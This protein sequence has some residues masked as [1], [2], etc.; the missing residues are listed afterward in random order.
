M[1]L[2]RYYTPNHSKA[3]LICLT[4]LISFHLFG[5]SNENYVISYTAREAI[6]GDLT[7]KSKEQVAETYQ[8]MDGLGR[9]KQTVSR[10]ASPL[11][12]DVI[13]PFQYDQFGRQTVK[14]L[15]Y[16]KSTSTTGGF[17]SN[18][19]AEIASFYSAS[20]DN[21]ADETTYYYS[22]SDLEP[23]PLNRLE[24]A[25]GPGSAWRSPDK[26]VNY[27][28]RNNTSGD[29][30]KLLKSTPSS[31]TY[32]DYP[33]GKLYVTQIL[34]ENGRGKT[35]EFM[36]KQ[37]KVILK[38]VENNNYFLKTYYIYNDF[39][40]LSFVVQPAGIK[41]I[42]DNSD[43]SL[44]NVETFRKKWMFCYKY[45][46]RQRMIAKRVPGSDWTYMVYDE[47]DRLVLTQSGNERRKSVVSEDIELEFYDGQ[48]YL[49][50]G[51]NNS[52]TLKPGFAFAASDSR[53]FIATTNESSFTDDDQWLFTKYDELNRPVLTG[54]V[55][56]DGKDHDALQNEV[57]TTH[58]TV[59][60]DISGANDEG[61]ETTS[62]PG[63][64]SYE[65]LTATYYDNYDFKADGHWGLSGSC[66]TSLTTA[67]PLCTPRNQVTGSK[68]KVIGGGF[69]ESFTF[70]D[71]RY[72]VVKT[73]EE[74]HLGGKETISTEYYNA[75]SPLVSKT[76]RDHSG[77]T[78]KEIIEEYTY[79]HMDRVKT[80]KTTIGSDIST[81]TNTYNEI[82][83][84]ITKDL[85]GAQTVDYE[86][87]IR[88]WL[89]KIN[90]G[91][92]FSGNDRFGMELKYN[93]APNAQYN[94]NIGQM[95]WKTTGGGLNA[96]QQDYKYTYDS[97]NR[98]KSATYS[99]STLNNH[100][101]VSDISYDL[102]G[103]IQTLTRKLSNTS[104]DILD[105]DYLNGNQ[106]SSV[107]DTGTS[108]LFEDGAS[109]EHEYVYDANGNMIRDLN[110]EIIN[111]NY[112]HL[113]LPELVKF[114]DD[115]EVEY[116][117]DASGRKLS[118]MVDDGSPETTHY[119]GGIH[120]TNTTIKFVQVPDG[121]Y[122]FGTDEYEYHL[123]DHLGNV[124]ATVDKD[125][126]VQQRDD[127]YPFGLTF[128]SNTPS[129]PNLYKYNGKEEQEET[130]WLDYG[131]RM[132]DGILGRWHVI[133]PLTENF[134]SISAYTYVANN[135]I[136][137]VDPNGM[138][139]ARYNWKTGT[140]F[141][142]GEQISHGDFLSTL[143]KNDIENDAEKV[144]GMLTKLMKNLG[145][146]KGEVDFKN[147]FIPK[148]AEQNI[149][150]IESESVHRYP[151]HNTIEPQKPSSDMSSY[152]H[153]TD[154]TSVFSGERGD[155]VEGSVTLVFINPTSSRNRDIRTANWRQG[156]SRINKF[157][158]KSNEVYYGYA[159]TYWSS[160][161]T[162]QI[163]GLIFSSFEKR[164]AYI[165]NT[166]DRIRLST[167]TKY[168]N[169]YIGGNATS[170]QRKKY[171]RY[172]NKKYTEINY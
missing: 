63:Q 77:P 101:N 17:Q 5:Q 38:E 64:Q 144:V 80:I 82:G 7:G 95:L 44:L 10:R 61:Y 66:P 67:N 109:E 114:S 29:E 137:F 58:S 41:E 20:G 147:D 129:T 45:D 74:N 69:L 172:V 19:T 57:T 169:D 68:I 149:H 94:G 50:T 145:A 91:T 113:N 28:Y 118:M 138:F 75:V 120:Y 85:S 84:L 23:S 103:N 52:I 116:T 130:G 170:E 156:P 42:E 165:S 35:V 81:I 115:T 14:H 107:D 102:N 26:P 159:I 136:Y 168:Y 133:D 22:E 119:V 164:K 31:V 128:N 100:F 121:R 34:D 139:M 108:A 83:E 122:L 60:Y 110:K 111:I 167:Y 112:N 154:V 155:N 55:E 6:S 72:R 27:S 56:I 146:A 37:G 106:L 47:R 117:Y 104:V 46:D 99:S 150:D 89:R 98:I 131:A 135:P 59:K 33:T 4:I 88:G 163:A 90:G 48:S 125:G 160:S 151:T 141:K 87:N 1:K 9:S 36:D 161:G 39:G 143:S 49:V 43:W 166:Y 32:T 24:N 62:F 123:T 15:P 16:V 97:I 79:D 73:I 25:L 148:E 92:S 153:G 3:F 8:Y 132:Y 152:E 96:N 124:R 93:N 140:Y 13:A 70:Y 171:N 162:H 51:S 12:K 157:G 105:Y 65:V 78:A 11:G 134:Y 30:V 86:Y 18:W 76:T 21:I 127:Y 126:I 54:L 142:D 158:G 71:D 2:T 40:Q 53:D